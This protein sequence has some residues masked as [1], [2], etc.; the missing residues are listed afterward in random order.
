MKLENTITFI[1]PWDDIEINIFKI[2]DLTPNNYKQ[3]AV[4]PQAGSDC[5]W[6]WVEFETQEQKKY[7]LKYLQTIYSPQGLERKIMTII[8]QETIDEYTK[9]DSSKNIEY[10]YITGLKI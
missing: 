1:L 8:T 7:Y 5:I 4:I 3:T 10:D 2:K 6:L 9:D